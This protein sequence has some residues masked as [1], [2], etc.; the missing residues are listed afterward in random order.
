LQASSFEDELS[1][2]LQPIVEL[3]SGRLNAV[4]VLARWSNPMLGEISAMEFIAIAERSTAIHSI[5]RAVF[6][7]G[8][9]AAQHLPEH[10]AVSFNI[11][12]CDLTSACTLSFI[13][14]EIASAGIAPGRIWIEVTETAVMRNAD[15]A[16][17]ALQAFRDL[18]VGIALDDFGTGYSSLGYVQRLPLDKIKIDRSFVSA[19]DS[20][21]GGTITSAVITLCHTIGLSCV[22]EGVETE[23]QRQILAST[24]CE[25]GQG[26]LFSKPVPLEELLPHCSG[27]QCLISDI[28]NGLK[29][30]GKSAVA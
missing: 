5:T 14:N 4:E 21:D 27:G 30:T 15:A 24:G 2:V 11:S 16:A 3:S 8:L 10:V 9:K 25:Y 18:G 22:A 29:G 26:Y 20:E 6:K 17:Q 19:L 23:A 7:K 28:A 13:R 1:I 12:A